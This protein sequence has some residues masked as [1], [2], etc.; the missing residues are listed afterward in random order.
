VSAATQFLALKIAEPKDLA[1]AL[2]R[3]GAVD[4]VFSEYH[5]MIVSA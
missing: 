5:W 1:V 4:S 3:G 2:F